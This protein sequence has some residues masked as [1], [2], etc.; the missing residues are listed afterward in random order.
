MNSPEEYFQRFDQPLAEQR[1]VMEHQD[2]EKLAELQDI[3]ASM[4]DR[5]YGDMEVLVLDDVGQRI[6]VFRDLAAEL[7]AKH[8]VSTVVVK[9][10]D[11][12]A[13][14]SDEMSRAQIES[15]QPPMSNETDSTV[16]LRAMPALLDEDP[17]P[18]ISMV[19]LTVMLIALS[20]AVT[21]FFANRIRV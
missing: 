18:G 1:V 7:Q 17:V 9:S 5:P 14:V 3:V 12:A 2:P 16:A 6:D 20:V 21:V 10:P 11:L 19:G 13:I 8:G 4:H 15:L